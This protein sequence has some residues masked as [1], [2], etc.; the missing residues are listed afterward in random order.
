MNPT[1]ILS[2]LAE[3]LDTIGVPTVN[4]ENLTPEEAEVLKAAVESTGVNGE[5][6]EKI[7]HAFIL[8]HTLM[9]LKVMAERLGLKIEAIPVEPG[10]PRLKGHGLM[11]PQEAS[12]EEDDFDDFMRRIGMDGPIQ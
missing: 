10:D 8:S 2:C 11:C 7:V 4:P 3:S 12:Q 6:L 1:Q 9:I 5:A